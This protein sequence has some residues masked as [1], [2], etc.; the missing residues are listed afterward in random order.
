M[1]P[2]ANVGAVVLAAGASRRLGQ[3]KQLLLHRGET[4]VGRAVRLASEAGAAPV[5]TVLGASRRH[6]GS[7]IAQT[8]AV[9]VVNELWEQGIASSIHAGLGALADDAPDASGVLLLACDQLRLT[10]EH[11]RGLLGEFA[12]REATAI[13]ASSYDGVTGVPAVFPRNAFP[14]LLALRGDRGARVLLAKPPCPLI[15]LPF[16]GGDVDI[17][18]PGDLA[19]LE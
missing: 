1:I 12:R 5:V 15:T 3:P 9:V 13:V 4:L 17:D 11:L 8:N 14:H 10:A 7:S 16:E 18:E 19:R 2:Q 6:I